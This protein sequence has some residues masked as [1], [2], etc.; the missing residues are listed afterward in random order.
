[1]GGTSGGRPPP[2]PPPPASDAND[3]MDA[4][5]STRPSARDSAGGSATPA[6]T[7][8]PC[9]L[10]NSRRAERRWEAERAPAQPVAAVDD[11][12]ASSAMASSGNGAG[13]GGGGGSG[14]ART[15]GRGGEFQ[16]SS[17]SGEWG[18]R[19]DARAAALPGTGAD[20][21]RRTASV[22]AATASADREVG[23]AGEG[24]P[25]PPPPPPTTP[26]PPPPPPP[27]PP[28]RRP[29]N[30]DGAPPPPADPPGTTG[31]FPL[32]RRGLGRPA[33]SGAIPQLPPPDHGG[34]KGRLRPL[35]R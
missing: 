34:Y 15:T 29:D 28:P 22:T 20:R 25:L 30:A 7:P 6:T 5:P 26:P 8:N 17:G 21:C 24:R 31:G 3:A 12:V 16:S 32:D 14:A 1:M 2:P 18:A 19:G 11:D 4:P 27:L 9:A 35:Q 23:V 33:R 13:G 10:F